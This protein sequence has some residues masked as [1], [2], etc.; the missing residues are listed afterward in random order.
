MLEIP[1][2]IETEKAVLGAMISNALSPNDVDLI[3]ND[4]YYHDHQKIFSGICELVENGEE[5][6]SI[7][8]AETL[9]NNGFER[10][11]YELQQLTV[12]VPFG[13]KFDREIKILKEKSTRRKLQQLG[14]AIQNRAGNSGES[15]VELISDVKGLL[16]SLLSETKSKTDGFRPLSEIAVEAAEK[17][18]SLADGVSFNIPTGI[19][20]IDKITRG[21]I[22]PGDVWVIGAFT[23]QGKSALA[24][25][26]ARNQAELGYTVGAVSR[27]MLDFENFERL[28]SAISKTPLWLIKP[29]MD[30][31]VY[32]H[33]VRTLPDVANLPIFI[34]SSSGDIDT[35]CRKIKGFVEKQNA[36]IIY[37]DYLQLIEV[38]NSKYNRA[39]EVEKCSRKIKALA[40]DLKI[41]I[42]NLAQYNRSASYAGKAETF[43]FAESS[44][45]EKDASF[46]LHLELEKVEEG[47][48]IPKWR[49]A[50]V[51]IGKGRSAPP[52]LTTLWFRGECFTFSDRDYSDIAF[53]TSYAANYDN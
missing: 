34:D 29:N 52:I 30:S 25:Q 1:N 37:I 5:V 41:G 35:I 19:A 27:E 43:H 47:Q 21:G 9:K 12:G 18:Q 3:T 40:M 6:N 2:S 11:V 48:Q 8:L 38:F 24:L 53:N 22:S 36:K 7:M 20:E 42:I 4:F 32:E 28:H 15:N 49:K 17:Y 45:I 39:Q 44:A 33:L 51:R 23:G 31:A 16:D 26:M 14:E 50:S 46:V 10:S 13:V